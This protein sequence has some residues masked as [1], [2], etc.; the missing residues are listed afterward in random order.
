VKIKYYGHSCFLLIGKDISIATDPYDPSVGYDLPAIKVDVVT[1]SH[2][3]F[4]HSYL[5]AIRPGAAVIDM[6]GEHHVKGVDIKGYEVN[7]DSKGG[8]QRGKNIIFRMDSI[9][10]VSIC[11]LGDLGETLSNDVVEKIKGVDVLFAPVGGFFTLEPEQMLVEVRR[12]NPK[13]LIP[14]HFAVETTSGDLPIKPVDYFLKVYGKG[15]KLNSDEL[16]I[17]PES[18][19]QTTRV[20]VLDFYNK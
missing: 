19:P 13:I 15:E 4:D 6:P 12:I 20:Y 14:M 1:V 3:H 10:G 5:K 18:L 11:H 8:T 16:E 17:T 7:H 9:D 2:Q